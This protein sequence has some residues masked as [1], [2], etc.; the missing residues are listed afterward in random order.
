MGCRPL[1]LGCTVRFTRTHADCVGMFLAVHEQSPDCGQ[2][3]ARSRVTSH[4]HMVHQQH[5]FMTTGASPEDQAPATPRNTVHRKV[6]MFTCKCRAP[7]VQ[8]L[9]A[10]WLGGGVWQE[11]STGVRQHAGEDPQAIRA[12]RSRPAYATLITVLWLG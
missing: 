2:G 5:A 12:F 10:Q 8:K 6:Y 3:W 1:L 11:R 7:N 4:A 9:C